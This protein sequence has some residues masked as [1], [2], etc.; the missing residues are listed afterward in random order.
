VRRQNNGFIAVQIR[1][2]HSTTVP[3]LIFVRSL[4]RNMLSCGPGVFFD[5]IVP[6]TGK[7]HAVHTSDNHVIDLHPGVSVSE[8]H[9]P[10]DI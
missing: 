5:D 2:S 6:C 10:T 9:N 8:I 4:F 7:Y 3:A 1:G